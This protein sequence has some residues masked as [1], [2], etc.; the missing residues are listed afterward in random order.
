[1]PLPADWAA[2]AQQRADLEHEQRS[3]SQDAF[4]A[5]PMYDRRVV[6]AMTSSAGMTPADA[7]AAVVADPQAVP[8]A[9]E[10]AGRALKL[11]REQGLAITDAVERAQAERSGPVRTEPGVKVPGLRDRLSAAATAE[12]RAVELGGHA[13]VPTDPATGA[14]LQWSHA[15]PGADED[16]QRHGWTSADDEPGVIPEFIRVREA[17]VRASDV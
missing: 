4:A 5:D 10:V 11:V 17:G 13:L 8:A 15:Y 9:R 3:H 14:P 2:E 1:M 7:L 12:Q 16:A 6:E